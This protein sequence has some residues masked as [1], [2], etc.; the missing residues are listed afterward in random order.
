LFV[1]PAK[2]KAA[3]RLALN[4][5]FHKVPRNP[6]VYFRAFANIELDWD[7]L[8]VFITSETAAPFPQ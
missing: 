5:G 1:L 6:G 3:L 7:E 2:E 8:V 4:D